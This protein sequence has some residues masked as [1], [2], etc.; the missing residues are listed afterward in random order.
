MKII[1]FL[2][3][4]ILFV[5]LCWKTFNYFN[6]TLVDAVMMTGFTYNLKKLAFAL[7]VPLV[8][9][10]FAVVAEATPAPEPQPVAQSAEPP[11][12]RSL[13]TSSIK[14]EVFEL[15]RKARYHG[16]DP[17]IRKRLGLP[18]KPASRY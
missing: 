3:I 17:I 15:E 9:A 10:G 16:D 1:T 7:F 12:V 4:H 5:P 13:E 18:L 8:I 6:V 14:N 11:P 2:A